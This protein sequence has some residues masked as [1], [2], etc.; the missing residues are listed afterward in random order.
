[1]AEPRSQVTG[2]RGSP[3][4]SAPK[5]P[6]ERFTLHKWSLYTVSN[7]DG[8]PLVVAVCTA[9]GRIRRRSAGHDRHI[10]LRGRCPSEYQDPEDDPRPQPQ[11]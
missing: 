7:T 1:M 9:C 8:T 3:A 11:G 2:L 5:K 4:K 10:D 6:A